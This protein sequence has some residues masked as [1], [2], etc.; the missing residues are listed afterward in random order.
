MIIFTSNSSILILGCGY[1]L[2]V[3]SASKIYMISSLSFCF[4]GLLQL[5]EYDV[6]HL[7]M[8]NISAFDFFG[9][10]VRL[11]VFSPVESVF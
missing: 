7:S 10:F 11:Y 9:F 8:S 4:A 1:Y 6:S 3:S 2:L 5:S